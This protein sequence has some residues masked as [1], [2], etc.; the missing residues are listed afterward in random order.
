MVQTWGG[1]KLIKKS[2]IF[3]VD[4]TQMPP[5]TQVVSSFCESLSSFNGYTTQDAVIS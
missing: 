4:H 5:R 3:L 2:R 1:E